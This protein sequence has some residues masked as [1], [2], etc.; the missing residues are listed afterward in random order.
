MKLAAVVNALESIAPTRMAE[1]WD[2]VGLL[3]GDPQQDVHR[4]LLTIDY[5]ADVAAEGERL[6]C[7][8]VIAYH[9]PIFDALKRVT[10]GSLI[11]D[12]IRR[13]VAVYSPHTALDV[14][15]GGTNDMLADAVGIAAAD[16]QALKLI[17]PK[18]R[19][20]KLIVF[21]PEEAIEKVSRAVFDAGAGQIGKYS[22]CS[23]QSKGVGTFIGEQ[24][25]NPAVG[26]PGKL[27]RAEEV[28]LETVLPLEKV[29][30][31]VKAVRAS[32]PYEEPAFDL[33]QLGV[34]AAGAGMG[35]VGALESP[36]SVSAV[37]E[38]MKRE[39][40]LG[41]V[42]VAG[43]AERQVRRAAVCAGACGNLLD[44][45]IAQ[46]VDLYLTGEMRHHDAIKAA[47]AG[48][49]VICTLH[50]NSERAVLKRLRDRLA[51]AASGVTSHVSEADAD[52]FQVR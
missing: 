17:Q 41:H 20:C 24:G 4:A 42:L 31:V 8:M 12:A 44:D 26:Q 10:A 7:E 22:S 3:V 51:V 36:Q 39:L 43:P 49:T 32:H 21:V 45:A 13:G 18:A 11:F 5:T 6:G 47:K 38:R 23:F 37:V 15:E 50:S 35:R 2:N 19:E 1:S 14:A 46:K 29:D 9:P 16:R 25:T 27:E 33:V 48:L 40:G 28:R 34:A 52:P 30:A